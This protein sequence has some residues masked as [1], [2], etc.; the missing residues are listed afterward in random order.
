MPAPRP[1]QAGI[2]ASAGAEDYDVGM[3]DR[4]YMDNSATSFPK[5]AAVAE[6]M[7][8]FAAA[9]CGASGRGAYAEAR[10]CEA[11]LDD[12]RSRITELINAG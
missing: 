11:I 5:P 3:S 10:R 8:T 7:A 4:I 6:A 12:C 2:V 9:E 1:P